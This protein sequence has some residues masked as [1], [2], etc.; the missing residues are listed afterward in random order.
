MSDIIEARGRDLGSRTGSALEQAAFVSLLLFAAALQVSIAAAQ[1]LLGLTA[2]LWIAL[3]V[4]RRE[5][6][7]VPSMFWPLAAYAGMTLVSTIFS[8]DPEVSIRDDKQ[9]LLYAI[10][11][12]AYR[13]DWKSVV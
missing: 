9:L 11:P 4:S 13:L 6:I 2:L 1:T 8:I 3:I 5:K 12:I 10:V 7:D